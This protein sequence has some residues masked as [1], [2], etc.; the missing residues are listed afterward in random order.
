MTTEQKID[1][2]VEKRYRN[3]KPKL[4]R[5]LKDVHQLIRRIEVPYTN[6][7]YIKAFFGFG[8]PEKK[9]INNDEY[10]LSFLEKQERDNPRPVYKIPQE[11][12]QLLEGSKSNA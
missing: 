8:L 1:E 6:W 2:L 12:L 11:I 5:K 4:Y 10:F 7:Q 3:Y 9:V